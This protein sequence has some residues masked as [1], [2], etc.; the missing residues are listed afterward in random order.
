M[1]ALWNEDRVDYE[2][3]DYARDNRLCPKCL[4][5]EWQEMRDADGWLH[6]HCA[7]CDHMEAV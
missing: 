3:L 1:S 5:P 6:H 7:D 2:R 4:S